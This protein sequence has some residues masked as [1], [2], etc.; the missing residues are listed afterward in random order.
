MHIEILEHTPVAR[1]FQ[2][3]NKWR[4]ENIEQCSALYPEVKWVALAHGVARWGRLWLLIFYSV[5]TI[6]PPIS[7]FAKWNIALRS[8]HLP[9]NR[10]WAGPKPR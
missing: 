3:T 4:K 2:N 10:R 8:L 6:V 1:N 9:G 5:S 7:L